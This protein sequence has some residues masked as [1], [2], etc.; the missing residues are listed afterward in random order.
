MVLCIECGNTCVKVGIFNNIDVKPLKALRINTERSLSSEEY[1]LRL[2]SVVG[3]EFKIDGAIISTVVP[4]LKEKMKDAIKKAF[5]IDSIFL[6]KDSK[7]DLLID[8]DNP[9]ELGLDF[10]CTAVG[11]KALGVKPPFAIADF[12][13]CTKISVVDCEGKFIGTFITSGLMQ[14]LIGLTKE[15]DQL[16]EVEVDFP[17]KIIGK[18]TKDSIQSGICFGQTFLVEETVRR[19]EQELG[20]SLKRFVCGGYGKMLSS[21]LSGF[22]YEHDLSLIGLNEIYKLNK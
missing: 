6:T 3:D 9:S 15:C 14:E 21:N 13:T 10:I 5:N 7:T 17:K 20:Y 11:V 22:K 18:N 16:Y 1:S 12:G 4:V 19:M 2:K 8:I